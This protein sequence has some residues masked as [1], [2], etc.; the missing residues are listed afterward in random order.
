MERVMAEGRSQGIRGE[1][2][3][4][5]A[6]TAEAAS[7]AVDSMVEVSVA[8]AFMAAVSVAVVSMAEADFMAAVVSVVAATTRTTLV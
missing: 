1:V 3:L 4:T 7:T 8:V 6:G 2:S 5:R